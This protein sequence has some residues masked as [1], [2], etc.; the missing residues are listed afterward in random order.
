MADKAESEEKDVGGRPTRCSLELANKLG[1][2]VVGGASIIAACGSTGIS[3]TCLSKWKKRTDEPYVGFISTLKVYFSA[4]VADAEAKV[5]GGA[6]GW[7][8]S[9]RW[10]ESM[11]RDRWCRTER[12]EVEV[13]SYIEVSFPDR[14]GREAAKETAEQVG[15]L[16]SEPDDSLES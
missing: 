2:L 12:R 11:Q 1:S 14:A 8:A 13:K 16:L 15:E 9:A 7:Q 6:K 3:P 4:A 10:L 5:Y